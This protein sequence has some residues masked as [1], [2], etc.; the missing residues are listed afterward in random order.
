[1]LLGHLDE[2][3]RAKE[4]LRQ[5]TENLFRNAIALLCESGTQVVERKWV[6]GSDMASTENKKMDVTYVR[7]RG[8]TTK[9]DGS[10]VPVILSV[11]WLAIGEISIYLCTDNLYGI[12]DAR[13]N[14]DLSAKIGEKHIIR[15]T[16]HRGRIS[17]AYFLGEEIYGT[18][19][20][21]RGDLSP[22]RI[23]FIKELDDWV[24][25]QR[26]N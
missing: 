9:G 17:S 7:Y 16:S 6:Y 11:P 21:W 5:A 10:S 20:G 3:E 14:L 12:C 26:D 19:G 13:K 1:M 23:G 24:V 8:E 25:D 15:F 2:G 18:L 4:T 22:D